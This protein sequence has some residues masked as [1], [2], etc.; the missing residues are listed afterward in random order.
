MAQLAGRLRNRFLVKQA[1]DGRVSVKCLLFHVQYCRLYIVISRSASA[2][3]VI[4]QFV[5]RVEQS[6]YPSVVT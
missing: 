2:S 1:N 3:S 4:T 5:V 6:L